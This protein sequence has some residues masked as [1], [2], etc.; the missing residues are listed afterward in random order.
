[1]KFLSYSRGVRAIEREGVLAAYDQTFAA[2]EHQWREAWRWE[3]VR[4]PESLHVPSLLLNLEGMWAA[5]EFA[6][7][8]RN[9]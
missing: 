6:Y 3:E 8:H 5:D 1:M 4:G 9:L 7:Y 2:D